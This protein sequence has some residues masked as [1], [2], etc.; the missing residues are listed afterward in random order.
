MLPALAGG[1]LR[2]PAGA[3][4]HGRPGRS[5]RRP[6][7]SGAPLRQLACRASARAERSAGFSGPRVGK[8]PDATHKIKQTK[9]I[10]KPSRR[11][12]PPARPANTRGPTTRA[13]A[14]KRCRVRE[15]RTAGRPGCWLARIT[16]GTAPPGPSRLCILVFLTSNEWRRAPHAPAGPSRLAGRSGGGM[17]ELAS[18]DGRNLIL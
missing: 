8:P 2:T 5:L 11:R 14:R 15:C 1:K 9:S 17:C 7:L 6:A 18:D 12:H 4:W 16:T 13:R 3:P 10:D